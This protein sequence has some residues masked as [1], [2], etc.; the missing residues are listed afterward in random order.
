MSS[1]ELPILPQRWSCHSCGQCCRNYTVPVTH[2]ERERIT[3]QGWAE[4]PD[5]AGQPL[6]IHNAALDGEVLAERPDGACVFLDEAGRCRIHTR[7]GEAAKPLGC[8]MYPFVFNRVAGRNFVSLRFD[9]PSVAHSRGQPVADRRRELG[10][11]GNEVVA[12]RNSPALAFR[13]ADTLPESHLIAAAQAFEWII[14]D[15]SLEL[16]RRILAGV[17]LAE[18]LRNCDLTKVAEL[19]R[20]REFLHL[21]SDVV[22]A[23]ARADPLDRHAPGRLVATMFRT[24]LALYAR[25]DRHDAER[26]SKLSQVAGT[27]LGAGRVPQWQPDL[28]A[29]K[30]RDLEVS[31]GALPDD[32]TDLLSRNLRSKLGGLG[33]F[34]PAF[35]GFPLLEGLGALLLAAP[36]TLWFARLFAVG[37]GR[38]TLTLDDAARA[39]AIVEGPWGRRAVF[40]L[41]TER[42]HHAKLAEQP[43]LRSLLLW[44]GT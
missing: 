20:M 8:R 1:L 14:A 43:H 4:E 44:Y 42:A 37:E 38:Q 2:E 31:F 39:L 23:D 3:A 36:L 22:I 5:F 18:L 21:A 34:G 7:F 15:G 33:F 27:L 12:A 10:R 13:N 29:V 25:R 19:D 40:R 30:F 9:C 17:N 35:H 26:Q 6:F 32:V 16:T 41:P 24:T 11:L 28:P